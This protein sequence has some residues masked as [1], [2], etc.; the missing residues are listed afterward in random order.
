MAGGVAAKAGTGNYVTTASTT[1]CKHHRTAICRAACRAAAGAQSGTNG[2][3]CASGA[4][5]GNGALPFPGKVGTKVQSLGLNFSSLS[6]GTSKVFL[7]TE[8]REENKTSWYSG[9][10]SYVVVHGRSGWRRCLDQS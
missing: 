3:D 5:C 9:F 7:V 4:Y 8:S 10:A 6:D 2:K 1:L